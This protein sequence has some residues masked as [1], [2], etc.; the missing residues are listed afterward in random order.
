MPKG[1]Q[2]KR[3]KQSK[4]NMLK[5]KGRFIKNNPHHSLGGKGE[6]QRQSIYHHIRDYVIPN[7]DNDRDK[8]AVELIFKL[9][10]VDKVSDNIIS[11]VIE[12]NLHIPFIKDMWLLRNNN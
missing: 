7:L 10:N 1:Q 11:G 3:I 9:I 4:K 6:Q 2:A 5:N 12:Q 8:K